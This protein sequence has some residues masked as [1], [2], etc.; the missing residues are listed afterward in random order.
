[1]AMERALA[2]STVRRGASA[3]VAAK[4][5]FLVAGLA[6]SVALPIAMGQGGFGA[7]KR[8]TAFANLVN[9]V[10]VAASMQ[11]V[12]R[13]IAGASPADRPATLRRALALASLVAL[14]TAGAFYAAIP[15]MIAHQRDPALAPSLLAV[16]L[17]VF[18]Y[19]IYA[20]LVGAL[21]G[22]QRFGAQ[23]A[24]DVGYATLRTGLLVAG[25]AA[26]APRGPD[27][28]AL[29]ACLGFALAAL[30]ILPIALAP[31]RLRGEGVSAI[32][33]RAHLRALFAILLMQGLGTALLQLDLISLGRSL[34]LAAGALGAAAPAAFADRWLGLYAQA[35][36]FGLIP[37]QLL[38]AA[39]LVLFP[40]VARAHALDD[41]RA[42]AAAVARGGRLAL[43]LGGAVVAALAG[44]PRAVLFFV[45][46]AGKSAELAPALGEHVLRGLAVAHLASALVA[47]AASLLAA[48]HRTRD[49]LVVAALGF[50]FGLAG[51]SLATALVR[52][53]SS[54]LVAVALALA[55]SMPLALAVAHRFVRR[56][57]GPML[58]PPT[59]LRVFAGLAAAFAFGLFA[60]ACTHRALAPLWSLAALAIYC[61]VVVL[62]GEPIAAARPSSDRAGSDPAGR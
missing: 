32:E 4:A 2:Q 30:L 3:I 15:L 37:Y 42:A 22:E 52:E 31:S 9:N 51:I 60:P 53:P 17:V 21:N 24:L 49:A 8:A 44:A 25:G 28:A 13:A 46:G 14:A 39:S 10:L 54:L 16:G 23:A 5:F 11:T 20:T 19:P 1:M 62:A 18:V 61:T 48:A 47:L 36:T 59:L 33:P 34:T 45:Y 29:G 7:Y 41:R 38:L 43:L 12:A 26:L 55:V 35:Q 6:Q 50:A 57:I 56:A 58:A 27:A 40:I